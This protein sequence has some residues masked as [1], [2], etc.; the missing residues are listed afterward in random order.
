MTY[1]LRAASLAGD[2]ARLLTAEVQAEYA[3]RYDSPGGDQSPID[4]GGFDPPAGYFV[5]VYADE[6]PAGMGGWR[7]ADDLRAA[8]DAEIKR[9]YVRPMFQRQGLARMLL[10]ELERTAAAAGI[11]RLVLETGPVLPGAIEF[12][13]RWG[14]DDVEAFG[15]YT[16]PG[17]VHLGK[18]L[19]GRRLL[20]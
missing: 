10:A 7:H 12:Y 15:F 5:I 17:S 8:D 14:Y 1:E 19:K 2:D 11:A 3:R 20:P 16:G 6:V 9:L 4:S 13:R 18:R